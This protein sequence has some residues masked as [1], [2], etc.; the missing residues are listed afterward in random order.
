MKDG[1]KVIT[2]R[3]RFGKIKSITNERALVT[4]GNNEYQIRVEELILV[5]TCK[6]IEVEYYL[7]F[8]MY[9]VSPLKEMVYIEKKITVFDIDK[10]M[11]NRLLDACLKALS[12]KLHTDKKIIIK[13]LNII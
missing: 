7:D 10:P 2:S 9:Q 5:D 4:I 13:K 1:D 3:G 6:A 12:I 11:E 8:L